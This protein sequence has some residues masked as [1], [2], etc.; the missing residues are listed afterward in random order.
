MDTTTVKNIKP[1]TLASKRVCAV[2]CNF[3]NMRIIAVSL[4]MP[5]DAQSN[6]IC[7][8]YLDVLN[9]LELLLY[10]DEYC[11]TPRG[12]MR[13]IRHKVMRDCSRACQIW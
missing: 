7:E 2:E 10:N 6:S 9:E 11:N 5:C 8:E 4:Y 1:I 3:N 13:N 12:C